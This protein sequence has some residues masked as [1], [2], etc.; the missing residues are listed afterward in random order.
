MKVTHRNAA[1]PATANCQTAET[2]AATPSLLEWKSDA[3]A[4]RTGKSETAS[5]RQRT[6]LCDARKRGMTEQLELLE[7][8]P[9]MARARAAADVG[10]ERAT[11]RNEVENPGWV[12]AAVM[13][14]RMFARHAPG[15]W[16]MEQAR[17]VIGAEL[18]EPTD[19]RTWGAVTRTAAKRGYIERVPNVAIPAASSN[20]SVKPA[21]RGGKVK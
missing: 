3:N 5:V 1:R 8:P 21:W 17:E 20:G 18:P 15:V 13:R 11:A 19:L 7:R 4:Q 16:T 10:I 9:A 6:L 2:A 12:D 14:L